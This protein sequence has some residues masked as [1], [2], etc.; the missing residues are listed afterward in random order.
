MAEFAAS[1]LGIISVGTKV[2][3]VLFQVASYLGSAG[4]DVRLLGT[5]IS[6]FCAVLNDLSTTLERAKQSGFSLDSLKSIGAIVDHCKEILER[7]QKVVDKLTGEVRPDEKS[8]VTYVARA[9]WIF[10]KGKVDCLRTKLESSK[11]TLS[12]MMTGF[13][14]ALMLDQKQESENSSAEAARQ[15]ELFQSLL[16][17][18]QFVV[19][20]LERLESD[21]G[22]NSSSGGQ[23]D[24]LIRTSNISQTL[25]SA[26]FED[27][28]AATERQWTSGQATAIRGSQTLEH[29]AN[30]LSKSARSS[31][32]TPLDTNSKLAATK[33]TAQEDPD[34]RPINW[35][36]LFFY[37][38]FIGYGDSRF[39]DE[40]QSV[41]LTFVELKPHQTLADIK[42]A[43]LNIAKVLTRNQTMT[44]TCTAAAAA[45]ASGRLGGI[46]I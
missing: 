18:Q 41:V 12:V 3:L 10:A 34:G 36:N 37:S 32:A 2:T 7:I 35:I 33:S 11:L 46:T 31:S 26:V 30:R 17:S 19:Q 45:P 43:I 1:L 38:A 40:P 42:K 44:C 29:Y 39:N 28:M 4:E 14:W 9:K 16:M 13:N 23:G 24:I 25:N 5:E 6:V 20:R 8:K 22:E 27:G 21:A 15:N